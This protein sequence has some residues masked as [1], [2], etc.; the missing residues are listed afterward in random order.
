MYQRLLAYVYVDD[1]FLNE[2]LLLNGL[3]K[4]STYPPNVK[5]TDFFIECQNSAKANKVGIWGCEIIQ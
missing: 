4:V 2:Q 5:Y 1:L 3:A